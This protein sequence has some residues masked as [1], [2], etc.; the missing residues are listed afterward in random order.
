MNIKIVCLSAFLICPT[1]ATAQMASN[2]GTTQPA[3]TNAFGQSASFSNAT[4]TF[5]GITLNLTRLIT[6]PTEGNM[7]R[8]VGTLQKSEESEAEILLFTPKPVLLDELGN[9]LE[10]SA[11]TGVAA[12]R[13]T[14][15][16][17]TKQRDCGYPENAQTASKLA[18]NVPVPF[19]IG[20]KPSE[21]SYNEELAALSNTVTARLHF[22]YSLDGFKSLQVAEVVIPNIPLPR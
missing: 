22:I 5:D 17:H 10:I 4:T 1:L 11:I 13:H 12:C 2:G 16:W 8:M 14:R 6:D 21:T 20:F 15:D 3:D 19:S 7:Y 18:P 9:A